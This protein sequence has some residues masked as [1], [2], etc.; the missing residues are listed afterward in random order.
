MGPAQPATLGL[1]GE[2]TAPPSA[3]DQSGQ[4][5]T[6]SVLLWV[7][8][9]IAVVVAATLIL[10]AIRGRL[11]RAHHTLHDAQPLTLQGM[12]EMVRNGQMT[13]DEYDLVRETIIARAKAAKAGS[14]P[15]APARP[16][17]DDPG[18]DGP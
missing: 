18:T 11:G 12:R 7:G 13:Q 17:P 3:A 4:A 15:Q 14:H 2:A 10:L 5:S 1:M 8:I 6:A 9:L 16:G